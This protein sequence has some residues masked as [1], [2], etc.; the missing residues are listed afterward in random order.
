MHTRSQRPNIL[1][2]MAD[3]MTSAL[4]GAYGHPVVQTPNLSRLAQ[5]GVRFDN[6]YTPYPLCG[7][8]RA[9]LAT[10]RYASRLGIWDNA[11]LF[12]ADELTLSHYLALAG[13]D[14][15]AS[16]KLHYVGPDQLHGFSR[17]LTT[18]IYPEDFRWLQNRD[19]QR[20]SEPALRGRHAAQYVADA[21]HTEWH[22]NLAYDEAVAY[23]SE[24]YLRAKGQEKRQKAARGEACQPFFL[25]ASFHHPHDPFRPPRSYWGLYENAPIDLPDYPANLEATYS[26]LDRWL[27]EW[28]S[29]EAFDVRNPESLRVVRRAYYALVTYI[30][31]KVGQLLRTLEENGLDDET[32]IIFASDHGD[33]LGE[34]GMVQ[35]RTFYDWSAKVPLIMRFPDKR[36][37]D[38]RI[39][40][41]VSLLDLMPT[42]LEIA[43]VEGALPCDGRSLMPLINKEAVEPWDVFSESHAEGIYGT[44]FMLRA[45]AYKYVYIVHEGG[46]DAQLFDM[47]NDPGE[48]KNLCGQAA[49]RELE[50]DLRSR[51]LKQFDPAAIE[52]AIQESIPQRDLLKRW[53]E[54][55]GVSWSYTPRF[56]STQRTLDQ[57][58]RR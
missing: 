49:Y 32:V 30:D 39:A 41:P 55:A 23:H 29:V 58:L 40:Q 42:L 46:T 2:I 28:H 9:V 11:S 33:M 43:G 15:V 27:N 6:A 20:A 47:R 52:Q 53:M 18:D 38:K 13:Y 45:E 10:G 44:C 16:G 3:Q 4:M 31:A 19:V 14:C 26:I 37:T 35:K 51:V 48:W 25:F 5:A 50:T 57:Y 21:I 24:Q 54:K 56:D 17:R 22:S 34:K 1:F 7:P 12:R 8:A 36:A